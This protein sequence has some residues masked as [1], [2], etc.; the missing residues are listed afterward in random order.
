MKAALCIA[1]FMGSAFPV[2]AQDDE[3]TRLLEDV[4][5]LNTR[6][7]GGSGDDMET[8]MAC[9]ARDYV[10]YLLSERGYCYGKEDQAG[11][12]MEWHACTSNSVRSSKPD[13][14]NP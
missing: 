14:A 10:S 3:T 5:T 2:L 9:G 13:I 11:F 12:E 1:V 6:C 8:W 4:V 7:R